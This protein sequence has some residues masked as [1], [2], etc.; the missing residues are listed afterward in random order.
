[1]ADTD[2]ASPQNPQDPASRQA[3]APAG[4]TRVW[5]RGAHWQARLAGRAG[6]PPAALLGSNAQDRCRTVLTI[7]SPWGARS[8]N[9]E[10]VLVFGRSPTQVP[11]LPPLSCG[12]GTGASEAAPLSPAAILRPW[13]AA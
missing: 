12:G 10:R 3:P 13:G 4:S 7:S 5:Y 11:F 2:D 6:R 9:P 8:Q 1:M